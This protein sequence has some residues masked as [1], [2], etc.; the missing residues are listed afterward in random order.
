[1]PLAPPPRFGV[2]KLQGRR[3][4]IET[5]IGERNHIP[6]FAGLGEPQQHGRLSPARAFSQILQTG[7][8]KIINQGGIGKHPDNFFIGAKGL[9]NKRQRTT[10]VLQSGA[11]DRQVNF[12]LFNINT[13]TRVQDTRF[14]R[15]HFEFH[16]YSIPFF[17][18]CQFGARASQ[19]LSAPI[20]QPAPPKFEQKFVK[21]QNFRLTFPAD[22]VY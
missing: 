14:Y 12:E 19:G 5:Y 22:M 21:S 9:G 6:Y 7:I 15:G 17:R 1:M 8:G 16:R 11:Q 3:L 10:C 2:Q 18:A 13:Q 20:P 4:G